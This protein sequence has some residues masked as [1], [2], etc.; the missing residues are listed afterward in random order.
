LLPDNQAVAVQEKQSHA[1]RAAVLGDQGMRIAEIEARQR[2]S[3]FHLMHADLL[4]NI[5]QTRWR[6]LDTYPAWQRPWQLL[7]F[8]LRFDTLWAVWGYRLKRF[9]LRW[10]VPVVPRIIDRLLAAGY[11]V[12][13]GDHVYIGP[14]LYIPH[15]FVVIDGFVEIGRNCVIS[16]FATIGLRNSN[17]GGF[18]FLGPRAGDA[19]WIGTHATLLGDITLGDHTSIGANSLVL[20]D[21]PGYC[22]AA[23]TPARIIRQFDREEFERLEAIREKGYQGD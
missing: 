18:S 8:I 5:Y 11:Q 17:E 22:T 15:G 2:P 21:L 12:Q 13:I 4:R 7:C 19:L 10:H 20:S 16:P 6:H 3:T 23:G 14:G 1:G 9:F